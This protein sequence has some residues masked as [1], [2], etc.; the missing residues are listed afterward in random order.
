[1]QQELEVLELSFEELPLA[2]RLEALPGEMVRYLAHQWLCPIR[3]A[4]SEADAYRV[5][6]IEEP[7]LRFRPAASKRPRRQ[8]RLRASTEGTT[9]RLRM[10]GVRTSLAAGRPRAEI[11]VHPRLLESPGL[12][13]LAV[14]G[15]LGHAL[16]LAGACFQHGAAFTLDE[17]PIL[18]LGG[19][20]SG[21]STV[22][23]AAIAA[24][25]SV[26][27]DD[28]LILYPTVQGRL[29]VRALRR[30]LIL[31]EG[32]IRVLE[33]DPRVDLRRVGPS[34]DYRWVFDRAHA[35]RLFRTT[36]EP[37]VLCALRTDR[38][39]KSFRLVA[40]S[41][42]EAF[43]SLVEAN[44]SPHLLHPAFHG[45]QQRLLSLWSRLTSS[46]PAFELRL[47]PALLESPAEVLGE[48]VEQIRTLAKHAPEP[49]SRPRGVV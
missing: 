15:A 28:S 27:S 12:V 9:T 13:E 5:R 24:G 6:L 21:K 35:A 17:L 32:S 39:L 2:L 8:I 22:A 20:S 11:E 48:V 44:A 45:E 33:A 26:V 31:R 19:G 18:L 34:N 3:T 36:L 10:P 14:G 4:T 43:T 41:Q 23:A 47:G 29:A 25:G 38:R 30:E 16:A 7:R 37:A 40:L 42:A 1:M 46:L 49:T